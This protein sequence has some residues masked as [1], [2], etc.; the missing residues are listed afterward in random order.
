M[1]SRFHILAAQAGAL[2]LMTAAA[3]MAQPADTPRNPFANDPAAI[4]AGQKVFNSTCTACH[5]VGA[6]GGR[7][8]ALNS[9]RFSHGSG[10]YDLFQTIR[11][12]VPGTQ[13]P[14]F[15]ALPADD[16]WRAVTY[17]KSLAGRGGA[18]TIDP[19]PVTADPSPSYPVE[20]D[21]G[22]PLEW[23]PGWGWV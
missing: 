10:D 22:P 13:M 7:G 14:S 9:G 23:E 11:T 8:P 6:T 4:A 20:D 19:T 17:I 1:R 3:A 5:G 18:F 16:V 12:G 2:L 21:Y 15:G